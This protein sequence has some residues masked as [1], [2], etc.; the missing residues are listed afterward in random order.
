MESAVDLPLTPI[1][2]ICLF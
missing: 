1:Y 2:L